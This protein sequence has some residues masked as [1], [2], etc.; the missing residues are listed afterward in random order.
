MSPLPPPP[1]DLPV[2]M[3][4][5]IASEDIASEKLGSQNAD[6][7][8]S[9]PEYSDPKFVFFVLFFFC[10]FLCISKIKWPKSEEKH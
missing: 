1:L 10:F 3:Y 8:I 9:A 6:Q 4:E 5:K 7:S 2:S